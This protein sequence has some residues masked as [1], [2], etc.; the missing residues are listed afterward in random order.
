MCIRDSHIQIWKSTINKTLE[1]SNDS[2][3]RAEIIRTE[4]NKVEEINKKKLKFLTMCLHENA[5]KGK[6]QKRN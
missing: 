2:K 1:V 3:D 5:L 6:K 4:I